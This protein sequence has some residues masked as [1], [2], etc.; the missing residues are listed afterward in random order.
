MYSQSLQLPHCGVNEYIRSR[1]AIEIRKNRNSSR[2][3]DKNGGGS[4]SSSSSDDI[5]CY[6][7]SLERVMC[8]TTIQLCP[9]PWDHYHAIG[10]A[11]GKSILLYCNDDFNDSKE[12]RNCVSILAESNGYSV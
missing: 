11:M 2:N 6:Q 1:K 4:S 8:T 10:V 5:I 7:E 9:C 12:S 3:N